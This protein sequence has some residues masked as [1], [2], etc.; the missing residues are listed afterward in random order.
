MKCKYC[1][2]CNK[3]YQIVVNIGKPYLGEYT[4]PDII[5]CSVHLHELRRIL[6]GD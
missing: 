4:T 1:Q 5:L 6:C 2:Y 3:E